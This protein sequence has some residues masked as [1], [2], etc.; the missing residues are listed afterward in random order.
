MVGQRPN[1]GLI[2]GIL[3]SL[4]LHGAAAALLTGFSDLTTDP[5]RLALL[6]LREPADVGIER[7]DAVTVTWIGFETETAHAAA[8]AET[9]QAE[10]APVPAASAAPAPTVPEPIE[11]P[12]P[13]PDPTPDPIEVA[14]SDQTPQ[15]PP[16]RVVPLRDW[17]EASAQVAASLT[18]TFA[19]AAREFAARAEAAMDEARASESA[20]QQ[21]DPTDAEPGEAEETEVVDAAPTPR[22]TPDAISD[23]READATSTEFHAVYR[24][25]RPLAAE[26]LELTTVRPA[27]NINTVVTYGPLKYRPRDV[28]VEFWFGPDGRVHQLSILSSSGVAEVDREIRKA[29]A[30]WRA[31]GAAI[32]ALPRGLPYAHEDAVVKR[33]I[34]FRL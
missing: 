4:V 28:L 1:A 11:E 19:Q 9:E 27:Y 29:S 10:V 21:G 26:G 30:K 7:S 3:A 32:D 13:G 31:K 23:P 25:G 14:E 18:R 2:I 24:P 12:T 33:R 22:P 20:L 5:E 34:L 17:Q 6:E 15:T 16:A 8:L